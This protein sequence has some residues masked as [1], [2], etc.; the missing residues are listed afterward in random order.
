MFPK[1]PGDPVKA[2]FPQ[3]SCLGLFKV[4]SSPGGAPIYPGGAPIYSPKGA[5][6]LAPGPAGR[7]LV[8]PPRLHQPRPRVPQPRIPAGSAFLRGASLQGPEDPVLSVP[9][10][11]GGF[12][13]AEV[14]KGEGT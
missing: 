14:P 7:S 6:G 1:T 8:R 2:A 9:A 13:K 10:Q 4:V 11:W 3:S 5:N 12:P